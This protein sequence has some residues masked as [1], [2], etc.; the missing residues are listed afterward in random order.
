MDGSGSKDIPRIERHPCI[1]EDSRDARKVIEAS[2]HKACASLGVG[3]RWCDARVETPAN[4]ANIP[5]LA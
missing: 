5:G 3:E 2:V 4:P 1:E